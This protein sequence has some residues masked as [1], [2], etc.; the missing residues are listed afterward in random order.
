MFGN[1]DI[2]SSSKQVGLSKVAQML[3]VPTATDRF[4]FAN[5]HGREAEN[6]GSLW[7][8]RDESHRDGRAA[9]CNATA[10][11]CAQEKA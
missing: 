7:T 1:K 6:H 5:S 3:I 10:F 8:E 4:G 9:M 11:F 2:A